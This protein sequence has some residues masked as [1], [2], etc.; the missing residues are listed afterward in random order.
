M[1]LIPFP[2]NLIAGA[3]GSIALI[4]GGYAL[5][6][7]SVDKE[8]T[9]EIAAYVAQKVKDDAALQAIEVKSNTKIQIQYQTVVKTIHD[10]G[11]SNVQIVTKYVHDNEFL[12]NGWVYSHDISASNQ[13]INPSGAS[14]DSAS[15][16][17]ANQA[18]GTV[19]TNYATCN[20]WRE[21]VIAWQE[22]VV[23]T[24]ADITKKNGAHK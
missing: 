13:L 14:D 2:Y 1:S 8:V 24:N 15:S 3:V 22:W 6:R 16:V 19:V 9:K 20:E 18:L 7:H 21:E 12:S 4:G 17:T 23:A 5:W 11:I 10:K